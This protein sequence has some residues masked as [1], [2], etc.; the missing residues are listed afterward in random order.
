MMS[1]QFGY[2][3]LATTYPTSQSNT[4][5]HGAARSRR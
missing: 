3:T 4:Q 1:E 5:A 2:S